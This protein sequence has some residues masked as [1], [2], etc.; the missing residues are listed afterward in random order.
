MTSSGLTAHTCEPDVSGGGD[1][2]GAATV[3]RS[4]DDASTA[5]SATASLRAEGLQPHTWASGDGFVYERHAHP[6]HK[7]FV[8]VSGGIVFHT[9]SGDLALEAG[10]RMELPAG[11]E[12][13][14]TVGP[15][16]VTCVEAYRS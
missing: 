8:C 16:G 10:D 14:A 1:G 12:H 3:V 6:H 9:D 2:P 4:A 13:A 5:A 15:A 11:A 7:V